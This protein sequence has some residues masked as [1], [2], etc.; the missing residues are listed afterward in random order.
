VVHAVWTAD[1]FRVIERRWAVSVGDDEDVRWREDLQ[2]SF[3]C[4][5]NKSSRLVA[6]DHEAS[7]IDVGMDLGL[8]CEVGGWWVLLEQD[9]QWGEGIA[10]TS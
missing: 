7:I 1:L 6:W 3:E 10:E 4:V 2:G 9:E 8:C 5:G